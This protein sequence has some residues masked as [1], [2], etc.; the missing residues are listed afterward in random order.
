ML[1]G[2]LLA[3]GAVA[4]ADEVRKRDRGGGA[5]AGPAVASP[6]SLV[7]RLERAGVSGELVYTD[8]SC[9]LHRLQ[10]PSLEELVRD[11]RVGCLFSLA[12]AR[13]RVAAGDHVWD[14]AGTS[15]A[16]CRRGRIEIGDAEFVQVAHR[17]P[18]CPPAWR[19]DGVLTAVT[20]RGIERIRRCAGPTGICA[21]VLVAG[22]VLA[23]AAAGHPEAPRVRRWRRDVRVQSFAWVSTTRV[24]VLLDVRI[25]GRRG[26]A[27]R[28]QVLALLERAR[29]LR[30][31]ALRPVFSGLLAS[32]RGSFVWARPNLLVRR[33]GRRLPLRGVQ[34]LAWS[35]DERWT[36][37]ATARHVVVV[38]TRRLA[39]PDARRLWL[40][41]EAR[42]LGW[43][44][45]RD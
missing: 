18:G 32:P 22:P 12:P 11:I 30:T 16:R 25:G 24:A 4:V 5:R 36:A 42:D 8:A 29:L 28:R 7:R 44:R 39:D 6:V 38:Q 34:A 33:D 17:L 3:L 13:G 2:A 40:P 23:R 43:A 19:P 37:L 26:Q 21:R 20:E 31:L 45:T 10:L 27:H 14:P 41:V 9:R 1:L 15:F 35:P